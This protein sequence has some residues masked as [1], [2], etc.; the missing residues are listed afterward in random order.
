MPEG[1]QPEGSI[2]SLPRR[3]I[4]LQDQVRAAARRSWFF[5]GYCWGF[6]F[7][8]ALGFGLA[9]LLSAMSPVV[10]TTYTRYGPSTTVT[11]PV[12]ILAVSLF[13]ARSLRALAIREVVLGRREGRTGASRVLAS[14]RRAPVP[15]VRD[16]P[17][18]ASGPRNSSRTGGAR[19]RPRPSPGSLGSTGR[20]FRRSPPGL[21]SVFHLLSRHSPAGRS[22]PSTVPSVADSVLPCRAKVD[23]W[24]SGPAGP[25]GPFSLATGAGV[26]LALRRNRH[27][28]RIERPDLFVIGRLLE[29]LIPGPLRHAQ[30]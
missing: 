22:P 8:G 28:R 1:G 5:S 2:N 21:V 3:L 6:V 23:P 9:A 20:G 19:P 30:L 15:P 4:A 24:V 14:R 11:S 7:A 29:A 25:A 17:S 26:L 16:G 10:T 18:P 27:G 12:W 13:P